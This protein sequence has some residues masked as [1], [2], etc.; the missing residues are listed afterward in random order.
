MSATHTH[1]HG[2]DHDHGHAHDHAPAEFD[3]AEAH[4]EAA[5]YRHAHEFLGRNHDRNARKTRAVLALTAAMMVFEIAAGL[6]TRSIALLADG[7]HMATHAGVMLMAV[8]AYALA[9]RR[10]GDR[11]YSFGVG[12]FGD[13]AAF[14]SAIVLGVTAFGI[15][16]EAVE[17]L[18]SPE[19]VAFAQ[20]LPVAVLGLA[21]NLASAWLLRDEHHHHGHDHG[22]HR[23]HGDHHDQDVHDREHAEH[24]DERDLNLRA[25]YVHVFADA[26][27]SVLAIGGLFLGARFGWTWTDAA[28]GI[29]GSL[30]IGRW[31]WGLLKDAG[32]VL[33]D[34]TPSGPVETQVTARLTSGG[35][36]LAD[37]HVWRVGP[38]AVSVAAVIVASSPESPQ[39]YRD[40]LGDLGEV[41]HA[42]IEV[43]GLSASR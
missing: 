20:A 40:R 27:V 7:L 19:H 8:A 39:A 23:V 9:Q 28:V 34:M 5:P 31:S 1:P 11:R 25:A 2:H 24:H 12:K 3:P 43:I 29:A 32:A 35:E 15:F 37:L 38:G 36:R 26:A 10:K 33:V 14:S 4:D 13:L 21:V 16:I 42:V 6:Y 41:R 18:L 17:R 30:V 22:H